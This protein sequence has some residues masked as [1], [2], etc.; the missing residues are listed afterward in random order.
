MAYTKPHTYVDGNVLS[1]D[2]HNQNEASAKKFVNQDIRQA[3]FKENTFNTQDLS[4]GELQP[5]TN[6]YDF[7]TGETQGFSKGSEVTN[8]AYFTS[9]IKAARQTSNTL[10]VWT[11]LY[12]SVDSIEMQQNGKVFITFYGA[13]V[14]VENTVVAKG[15]WDSKIYIRLVNEDGAEAYH[16]ETLA[17][18]FEEINWPAGGAVSGSVNPFGASG[19]PPLVGLLATG[20]DE[21]IKRSLRRPIAFHDLITLNKGRYRLSV[22]INAKVEEGFVSSRSF[23]T[24]IFYR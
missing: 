10:E 16:G 12:D 14:S 7:P 2:Q 23:S 11:S 18:T 17:Y 8:R 20:P 19:T 5:I 6:Q 21:D 22:V 4:T 3:D 13:F 15:F 1:A 9:N 24:E